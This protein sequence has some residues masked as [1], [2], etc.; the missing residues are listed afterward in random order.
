MTVFESACE[1]LQVICW[2]FSWAPLNLQ[3]DLR[4]TALTRAKLSIIWDFTP[5]RRFL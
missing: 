5:L 3:I 4:R 2:D 1:F